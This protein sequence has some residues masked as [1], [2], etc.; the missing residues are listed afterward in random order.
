MADIADEASEPDRLDRVDPSVRMP[1][2]SKLDLKAIVAVAVE[3]NAAHRT[4][5]TKLLRIE[6]HAATLGIEW[7]TD[8]FGD[9]LGGAWPNGVI[10]SL[11]DHACSLAALISLDDARRFVATLGL[12]ID[13][14]R[15]PNTGVPIHARAECYWTTSAVCLVRGAVFHPNSPDQ[16]LATGAC[17]VGVTEEPA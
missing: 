1:V 3:T 4:L 12:R 9:L 8:L 6:Q 5:S 11:L 16:V 7:Q 14:L 2:G 15:Q 17:T 10:A 13:Y